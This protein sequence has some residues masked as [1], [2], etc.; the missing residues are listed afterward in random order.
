MSTDTALTAGR[1]LDARVA[2]RVMGLVRC[3]ALHHVIEGGYCHALPTSRDRGGET[4]CYSTEIAA[5]W[6][7]VEKLLLTHSFE[8]TCNHQPNHPVLFNVKI[9]TIDGS[10]QY[11]FETADSLPLAI[12]LAALKWAEGR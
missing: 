6:Q 10:G 7:V 3:E 5:A 12:C 8:I 1:E 9:W 4:A 2:E 11:A